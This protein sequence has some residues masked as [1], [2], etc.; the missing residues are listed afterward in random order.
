MP[1]RACWF[2]INV[3]VEEH[4]VGDGGVCCACQCDHTEHQSTQNRDA[5]HNEVVLRRLSMLHTHLAV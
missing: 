3:N 5:C 1:D 4:F 2:A